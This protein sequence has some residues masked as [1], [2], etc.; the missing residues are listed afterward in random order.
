MSKATYAKYRGV[1]RQTI[2]DWMAK[3]DVVMSGNKIDVEATEQHQK[4]A[5]HQ[6]GIGSAEPR[7]E[8]TW[9]ECW[10]V[11]KASDR[12]YPPPSTSHEIRQ[13]LELAAD[14]LSW[15]VEFLGDKGIRLSDCDGEYFFEQY[16][17]L[18]NADLAIGMLR[19]DVCYSAAERP[20]LL[21]DW[22]KA[23]ILALAEWVRD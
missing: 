23:G 12:L 14:E 5:Q 16:D 13:R 22:S 18:Q 3:G 17:F 4:T 20:E 19:R 2:Y 8:M 21:D 1:S 11:I 7:I 10:Q 6:A 9:A 15:A